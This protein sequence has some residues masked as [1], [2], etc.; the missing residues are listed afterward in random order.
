MRISAFY[1]L[2]LIV[3][4]RLYAQDSL[5]IWTTQLDRIT[6]VPTIISDDKYFI[7]SQDGAITCLDKNGNILREY[8]ITGQIFSPPLV[9]NDLLV[10]ATFEGDLI[11]LN[12][13][14]GNPYQVIGIGESITSNILLIDIEQSG[15]TGKAIVAGTSQ[16]NMYCYN[17]YTLEQVWINQVTETAINSSIVYSEQKIFFQDTDG[18]LICVNAKNGSLLWKWNPAGTKPSSPFKTDL[19][20]INNYLYLISSNGDL[21]CID[22]MLGTE[23][24]SIKKIYASG[25]IRIIKKNQLVLP[26][27]KNKLLTV[28]TKTGKVVNEIEFSPETKDETVT[29]LIIIGD[30]IITGFSN[31]SVYEIKST[32]HPQEIFR[33]GSAAIISLN[34]ID[35]NCL[36]T[37]SDGNISL[38]NLSDLSK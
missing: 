15:V 29:D 1:S 22:A 13:I 4:I 31:G 6:S 19:K 18:T 21:Y 34:N 36:V 20:I 17:L 10:A 7:S 2:L 25:L 27:N 30:K 28:S 33:G 37:D 38:L 24:W 14:T 9:E 16:G 8:E 3:S 5:V 23:K 35:G 11:T 26:T 12:A 32:N